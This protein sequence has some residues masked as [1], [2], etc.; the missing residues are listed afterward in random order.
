VPSVIEYVK[1]LLCHNLDQ[2]S[3]TDADFTLQNLIRFCCMHLHQV[4]YVLS[5]KT[6]VAQIDSNNV[7]VFVPQDVFWSKLITTW[8]T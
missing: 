4:N 6:Q 8:L 3:Q 2:A 7:L 1:L 5:Y